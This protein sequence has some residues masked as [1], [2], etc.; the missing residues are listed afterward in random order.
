MIA[1]LNF[2]QGF[3]FSFIGTIPPGTINLTI[4]QL[5][6]EKKISVA[7][8]FAI[9]ASV[10]EYP[11]AWIAVEFAEMITASPMIVENMQLITAIIMTVLGILTLWS[12]SKPTK[13]TS[14]L[15]ESGYMKGII[16]SI[17]NPLAIPFWVG[18]TAY[19]DSLNWIELSTPLRLQSYL[20]GLCLGT[21]VILMLMA[22]LAKKIISQ[23]QQSS[24]IGKIPG[25]TLIILGI[26]AF[27]QYL[28]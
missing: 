6:L 3:F 19:L 22:F 2:L 7:W 23:F 21:F 18:A 12:A 5:G 16:L 13:L 27:F 24:W 10:M 11:Y 20:I 28:L 8:R 14:A 4:V 17:L 26:Y 25:I 1:I 9:A 15:S